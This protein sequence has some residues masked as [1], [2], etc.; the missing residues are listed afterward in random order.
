MNVSLL[1]VCLIGFT[2]LAGMGCIL[3]DSIL[4]NTNHSTIVHNKYNN[5]KY[6]RK[7]DSSFLEDIESV[8]V[9]LEEDH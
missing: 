3:L 4:G 5:N 6:M 8:S 9:I 7:S 1:V 2:A